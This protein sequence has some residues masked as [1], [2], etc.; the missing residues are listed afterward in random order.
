MKFG[1]LKH[2]FAAVTIAMIVSVSP[3]SARSS[4]NLPRSPGESLSV[5][6]EKRAPRPGVRLLQLSR[7][8]QGWRGQLTSDWYGT[9]PMQNIVRKGRMISF[10]MRNINTPDA[11]TRR[12]TVTNSGPGFV[13]VGGIWD[14][15]VHQTGRRATAAQT[16]AL[17]HREVPLPMLGEIAPDGLAATPPMGWSSWNRFADQIDDRTIRAMADALVSSGLREAG[18]RYVNIDDGWQGKRGSD[19]Q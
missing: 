4:V 1:V 3:V 12:W 19:G 14:Q 17:A 8:R 6:F 2:S 13:L 10:D 11:P 5:A 15:E 18:Y 16:E 9:M 7:T